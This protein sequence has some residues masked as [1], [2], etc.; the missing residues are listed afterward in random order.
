MKK[1]TII[2]ALLFVVASATAAMAWRP[3]FSGMGDRMDSGRWMNFSALSSL[4]LT[5]E[6]SERVRA[7]RESYMR[8]TTPLQT[9][10]F[11]KRAE[12]KLLWIQTVPEPDKIKAKQKEILGLAGQIQE[13]ATDCALAFRNILTPE[14]CSQFLSLGFCRGYGPQQGR[15]GGGPRGKG[16]G[17]GSRW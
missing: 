4:N 8:G 2:A 9:Q 1:I 15:R 11:N 12:L 5:T 6:Q 17:A 16:M 13:K 7:L 3:C 10:L 14:Q